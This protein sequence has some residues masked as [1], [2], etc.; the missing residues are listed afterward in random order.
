MLN[1]TISS[2]L[3]KTGHTLFYDSGDK[4]H[5]ARVSN[6]IVLVDSLDPMTWDTFTYLYLPSV[7]A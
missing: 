1:L 7:L 5:E 3:E 6:G 4:R 2:R